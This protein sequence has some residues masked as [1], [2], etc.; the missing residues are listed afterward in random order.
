MPESA[1]GETNLDSGAFSRSTLDLE[2]AA[3]APGPRS[4][5]GDSH[6]IA[7]EVRGLVA[8]SVVDDFEDEVAGIALETDLYVLRLGVP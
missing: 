6:P 1:D 5:V 7:G 2:V 3:E 4:H 8:D